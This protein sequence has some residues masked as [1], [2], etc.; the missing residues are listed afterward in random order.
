MRLVLVA[1]VAL[2]SALVF[3]GPAAAEKGGN[4]ATVQQCK[5]SSAAFR[6]LGQCV[7]GAN[8]AHAPGPQPFIKIEN[9][10]VLLDDNTVFLTVDYLCLPGSGGNMAGT[11]TTFVTQGQTSSPNVTVPAR[12]DG[13]SHTATTGNGPP[14]FSIGPALAGGLVFNSDASGASTGGRITIMAPEPPFLNFHNQALLLTDGTVIVTVDYVCRPG[15]GG[16]TAGTVRTFL[17]QGQMSTPGTTAPAVCDDRSHT[18]S[19][20][21]GP[22]PFSVGPALAGGLVLN[23]D[24]TGVTGGGPVT[25][26]PFV[27]HGP[28]QHVGQNVR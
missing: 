10:A 24:M 14:S 15:P 22:G 27:A 6:N 19:T 18:A 25:I 8:R 5:N 23:S 20:D 7:S 9:Q 4:K 17:T 2:M 28:S 16:N 21:N 3:A 1:S 13:I 11:V 26:S 12:C